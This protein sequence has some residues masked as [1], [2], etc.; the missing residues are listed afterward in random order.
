MASKT[1]RTTLTLPADLLEQIDRRVANGGVRSRNSYVII[2]LQRQ[3]EADEDA[4][5]DADLAGMADDEA[6][7]AEARAIADE[8]V[9]A[10]WE[11]LRLGESSQ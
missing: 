2:A 1:A 11:A 9:L 6:Y 5:I 4:A 3:L 7:L 10:D 8:F